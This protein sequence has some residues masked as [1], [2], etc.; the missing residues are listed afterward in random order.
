VKHVR[1]TL[2]AHGQEGD[3]HPMYGI[4]TNAPFVERATAIQ[5]NFTGDAL[6]ILHYVEGDIEA[7]DD[8]TEDVDPVI[9]YELEPAGEDAFYAYVLDEMTEVSRAMFDPIT[10]RGLVVLPPIR[11]KEDGTV[12]FS[13]FGP[14]DEIQ[15]AVEVMPPPVEVTIDEV[16]GLAAIPPAA[17]VR[18]SDRQRE[19]IE[20]ALELGYYEIPRE[21]DHEAVADAIGCAPSTAA[22]HLRKGE[23]KLLQTLLR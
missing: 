19:A 3:I 16:G 13:V 18:L 11:Y 4:L 1:V 21:A 10:Y 23:S 14:T 15:T 7:F 8:A 2:T 5:W 9:D 17:D 6:G 12:S 22:E 20:T